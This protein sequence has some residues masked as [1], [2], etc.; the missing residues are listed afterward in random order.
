MQ[1]E[2]ALF[3]ALTSIRRCQSLD[4]MILF[5]YCLMLITQY[6]NK[7]YFSLTTIAA[8]NYNKSIL[9]KQLIKVY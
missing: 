4:T 2:I 5:I 8:E 6:N 9:I 1:C 3:D 7:V